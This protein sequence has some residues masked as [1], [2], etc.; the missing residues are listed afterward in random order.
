MGASHYLIRYYASRLNRLFKF[1]G[2]R[3][4]FMRNLV[5]YHYGPEKNFSNHVDFSCVR[6]VFCLFVFNAIAQKFL[7]QSNPKFQGT[8]ISPRVFVDKFLVNLG[9]QVNWVGGWE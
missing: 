5:C 9:I 8:F 1:A 3:V 6:I 7:H 4:G 2:L